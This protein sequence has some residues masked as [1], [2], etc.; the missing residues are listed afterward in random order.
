[1]E[2]NYCI[3]SVGTGLL[4]PLKDVG[5]KLTVRAKVKRNQK[6]ICYLVVEEVKAQ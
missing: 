3:Y 5:K 6:G 1:V 2:G 4:N